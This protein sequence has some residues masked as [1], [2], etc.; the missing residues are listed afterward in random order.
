MTRHMYVMH[1]DGVDVKERGIPCDK[2]GKFVLRTSMEFHM[3]AIHGVE[4][5]SDQIKA[6]TLRIKCPTCGKMFR[7][8]RGL[9]RHIQCVHNKVRS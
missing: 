7:G 9:E 5:V 1:T 2:C 8:E 6:R 4:E 3:A